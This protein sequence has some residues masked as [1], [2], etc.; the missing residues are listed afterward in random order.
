MAEKGSLAQ[1]GD[2]YM[3][4]ALI[5]TEWKELREWQGSP[6]PFLA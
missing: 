1:R 3:K 6:V 2:T 5:T 4:G